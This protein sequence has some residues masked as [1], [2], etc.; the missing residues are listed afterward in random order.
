M[1]I[2]NLKKA[3]PAILSYQAKLLFESRN[4]F[5]RLHFLI[6]IEMMTTSKGDRLKTPL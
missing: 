1:L 2:T 5:S 4:A 6:G 3:P